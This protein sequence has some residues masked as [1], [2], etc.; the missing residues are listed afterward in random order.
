[1]TMM[2]G[3]GGACSSADVEHD[4]ES[5]L[6]PP[7]PPPPPPFAHPSVLR[8]APLTRVSQSEPHLDIPH[9]IHGQDPQHI[10]SLTRV[11]SGLFEVDTA[12]STPF[13][14]S[15][16]Q[17]PIG[18]STDK[19]VVVDDSAI[20]SR[21]EAIMPW[22]SDSVVIHLADGVGRWNQKSARFISVRRY[23]CFS[24][25]GSTKPC[26]EHAPAGY[27]R[28]STKAHYRIYFTLH[29]FLIAS[30]VLLPRV[31]TAVNRVTSPELRYPES[32][33]SASLR[34]SSSASA[35]DLTGGA[36]NEAPSSSLQQ[37]TPSFH[38]DTNGLAMT[39][40]ASRGSTS[41]SSA[42]ETFRASDQL[43]SGAQRALA[44]VSSTTSSPDNTI[45]ERAVNAH[46][47]GGV[48]SVFGRGFFAK[49][50]IR[51]EEENYRYLMALDR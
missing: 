6:P 5:H 42:A 22:S 49:P 39:T 44:D 45:D 50:V 15:Y 9:F 23:V 16:P 13:S 29:A 18:A 41:L 36:L 10:S 30:A 48:L 21:R 40:S 37:F 20:W 11:L 25:A 19:A 47:H 7:P 3:I 51:S 2:R 4:I 24:L 14:R 1:M 34:K 38:R 33:K 35:V 46:R 28:H 8:A 32:V 43:P 26:V 27:F 17:K 12:L 31:V